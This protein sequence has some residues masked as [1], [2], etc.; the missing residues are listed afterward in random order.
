[1]IDVITRIA[2]LLLGIQIGVFITL[3]VLRKKKDD[4]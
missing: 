4:N 1:M 3:Y 2:Y